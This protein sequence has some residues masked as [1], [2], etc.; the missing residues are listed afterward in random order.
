MFG[1]KQ[2][3]W[4]GFIALTVAA[5]W[6]AEEKGVP[7]DA[8]PV[9]AEVKDIALWI[10]QLD[11]DNFADRQAAGEKLFAAGNA[12]IPALT[13]AGASDNPEVFTR[14]IDLLQRLLNSRDKSTKEAAK[15]GLEKITKSDNLGAA[16]RAMQVLNPDENPQPQLPQAE[17]N[18]GQANVF[19]FDRRSSTKFYR[20]IK[21]LEV[22]EGN[23]K[24]VIERHP[25]A[26]IKME[27]TENVNGKEITHNFAAK[28]SGLLKLKSPAAFEIYSKY[29]SDK[30]QENEVIR[31]N[32]DRALPPGGNPIGAK[33]HAAHPPGPFRDPPLEFERIPARQNPGFQR[34]DNV[35]KSPLEP[36]IR[37]NNMLKSQIE[38]VGMR[39]D[40][41][42]VI[43]EE[44]IE[45]RK[46]IRESRKLLKEIEKNLDKLEKQLD[47][48]PPKTNQ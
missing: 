13:K 9:S 2:A 19:H 32:Q 4:A 30:T 47:K 12:A 28:D 43:T 3:V 18:L 6:A 11:A 37:F 5:A 24:I 45:V 15:A 44:R 22:A 16:R 8:K 1:L 41:Y 10:N 31:F 33:P 21:K 48:P 36:L 46:D 26:S 40:L 29:F 35:M 23:R 14:S 7:L 39:P 27:I 42:R 34:N 17:L 20:G 38:I 25:D